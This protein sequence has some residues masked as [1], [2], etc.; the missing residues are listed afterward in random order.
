MVIF[1]SKQK[2]FKDDLIMKLYG[3]RLCPTKSVKYLGVKTDLNFSWKNHINNLSIKLSRDNA[4]LFNMRNQIS[5]N[6]LRSTYFAI[7]VYCLS[8]CSLVWVQNCSTIRRI[9]I[10]QKKAV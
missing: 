3:K 10:L 4:L 9:L 6:T 5:F 8:Y 1:K 2:K 7:F